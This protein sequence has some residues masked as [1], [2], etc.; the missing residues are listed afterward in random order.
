MRIFGDGEMARR[1]RDFDWTPTAIGA[2]FEWPETL[3]AALNIMLGADVPI[4]IF[5]GPDLVVFY[6]DALRPAFS[7]K[8]PDSLGKPAREVWKEAWPVIGEQLEEVLRN[9]K[10]VSFQN[11]FLPLLQNGVL[12][13]MYWNYSYSP[14][15][16]AGGATV[17]VFDIAQEVTQAVLNQQLL[18]ESQVRSALMA[19][20][21]SQFF[22]ATS[23]AVVGLDRNW[24]M[25]YLNA[26]AS[27][28]YEKTGKVAGR[29]H[30][31]AFPDSIYEG[32]PFVEYYTR[33]MNEGVPGS[34]EAYYPEPLNL[35]LHLEVHPTRYGIVIFSRN[36]TAQR[37]AEAAM[38]QTE[39]LAATGRLAASI[40][41]EINNPLEAV[42][43]LLYLARGTQEIQAIQQY[44]D[45]AEK[46]LGRVSLITSQTLRFYKQS[47]SPR[48]VTCQDL[49]GSVLA[50]YQSRLTS[51]NTSVEQRHHAGKPVTCFEGEIRQ[52]LSNLVGNA[53]DAMHPNGGR[54]LL[55]S[56]EATQGNSG[57]KGIKFT[58]ADTGPGIPAPLTRKIFEAFYTTKGMSGTGLGLWVSNE[59]VNR[60]EG[61]LQLRTSQRNGRS[62]TVFTLFLPL[63]AATRASAAV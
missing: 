12:A 4:Q 30:W 52:V 1:I 41:H 14:I 15:Q 45:L 29:N 16:D 17:G 31:E 60:H 24:V 23:D 53:I 62:G 51:S 50:V 63:E 46:E 39:K 11:V 48:A 47:N 19:E 43:N 22:E 33:A 9:G 34:F 10:P 32:S 21:L 3:V 6:N 40:A 27:E 57:R 7:D 5:W 8:H 37:N 55:R 61:K 58:I 35:W 56:R 28:L 25:T 2:L 36:I 18:K 42:T 38:I 20:Q 54:L 49:F 44:L 59:I 13:D 26:K